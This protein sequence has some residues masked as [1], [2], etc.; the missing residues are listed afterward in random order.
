MK[1]ERKSI[2]KIGKATQACRKDHEKE[3]PPD[4][5]VR[6][7]RPQLGMR[8]LSAAMRVGSEGGAG[9]E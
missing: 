2:S 3:Q 9:E 4:R 5:R 8:V 6:L 1:W 7:Q